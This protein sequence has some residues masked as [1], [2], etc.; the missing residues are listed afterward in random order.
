[1]IDPTSLLVVAVAV[2]GLYA[3]YAARRSQKERDSLQSEIDLLESRNRQLQ[4]ERELLR[5]GLVERQK[6]IDTLRK[7]V[8]ALDA[9]RAESERQRAQLLERLSGLEKEKAELDGRLA[10]LRDQHAAVERDLGA[11]RDE[12]GHLRTRVLGFQG[13]W[14]RQLATVEE[15]IST[16]GRQLGEFRKGTRLPIVEESAP[17]SPVEDADGGEEPP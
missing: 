8:A 17:Q 2:L 12:H 7:Q 3:V 13:E 4:D 9:A 5:R 1:M 16:L 11:L 6:E 14:N 10:L 15:E